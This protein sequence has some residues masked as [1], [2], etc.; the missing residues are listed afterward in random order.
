VALVIA[1]WTI[2]RISEHLMSVKKDKEGFA[3]EFKNKDQG[4][5]STKNSS[6]A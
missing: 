4:F 2:R 1:P 5:N 6:S 3:V